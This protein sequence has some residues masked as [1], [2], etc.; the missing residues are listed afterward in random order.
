MTTQLAEVSPG[1]ACTIVSLDADR[2]MGLRL[3]EMGLIPGTGVRVV[4]LAPMGDPME[5]ELR[6]YRLSIR[7]AEA[8]RVQV[9]RA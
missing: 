3:M 9:E 2:Q 4:R 5:L 6:G 1:Q 8:A 7:L